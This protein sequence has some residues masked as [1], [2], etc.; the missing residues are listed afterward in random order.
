MGGQSAFARA[1][2][3]RRENDDLHNAPH[4][5]C[6]CSCILQEQGM[7]SILEVTGTQNG[8]G[9]LKLEH[10]VVHRHVWLEAWEIVGVARVAP[11]IAFGNDTEADSLKF[12]AQR[13]FLDAVQRVADGSPLPR[14]CG[15]IGDDQKSAGL[16]GG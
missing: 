12:L 13:T 5:C 10:K 11:E 7:A 4:K 6:G 15:V 3:A 14:Q 2:L 1:A 9:F 16:E 8:S